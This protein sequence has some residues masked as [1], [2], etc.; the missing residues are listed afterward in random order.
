MPVIALLTDF[1]TRDHYVGAVK[2]AVLAVCPQATLVDLLHELPPQDVEAG[3]FALLCAYR[4]FPAG[5]VFVAVVDPGVGS[6]RRGLAMEAGG[7]LFVAPDNG[8][9]GLVLSEWPSARTH[10]L[11][12]RALFAARVSRTFHARD[13]FGPVA[14]HLAAGLPLEE[15]GPAV[16][17]PVRLALPSARQLGPQEW[18]ASVVHVDRFGNLTVNLA[19][20][21]L[22]RIIAAVGDVVV[23]VE[24]AVLPLGGTYSDVPPGQ[25]CALV[26][27][28]GLLEVAV[29]QGDA[30]RL[31]GAGRGAP[32]RV[33]AAS[34]VL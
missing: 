7:Y 16:T 6:A 23:V 25:P 13:V 14:G 10:H 17:D 34:A 26:G 2:G 18:E 12:N 3:A 1:G 29:N 9:L 28:S 5:T 33:R 31:L 27:S 4:S 32:V 19:E 24:G 21:E 11:S 8:L 15:V 30:S 22:D 20:A